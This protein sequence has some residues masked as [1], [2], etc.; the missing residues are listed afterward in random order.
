VPDNLPAVIIVVVALEAI[1]E[2]SSATDML[3][4]DE[5]WINLDY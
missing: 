4:G 5:W 3:A 1:F 2:P